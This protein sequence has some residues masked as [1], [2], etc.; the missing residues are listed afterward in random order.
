MNGRQPRALT[1][2]AIAEAAG[3]KVRK[4]QRKL[5]RAEAELGAVDSFLSPESRSTDGRVETAMK[6]NL[7]A[8]SDVRESTEELEE[9]KELLNDEVAAGTPAER[10]GPSN[11]GEGSSSGEGAKSAIRHLQGGRK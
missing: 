8:K 3:R 9:V 1:P 2:A 10:S 7:A 11:Y 6:H 5:Q 4:V